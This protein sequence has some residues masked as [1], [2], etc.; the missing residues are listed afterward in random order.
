MVATMKVVSW[1]FFASV[2]GLTT[3]TITTTLAFSPAA[4]IIHI[5]GNDR[6]RRRRRS[7]GSSETTTFLSVKR[8][9]RSA[10]TSPT[11][12]GTRPGPPRQ[13]RGGAAPPQEQQSPERRRAPHQFDHRL[14]TP[15]P[16][17]VD[18]FAYVQTQLP[19][20]E[21]AVLDLL[22]DDADLIKSDEAAVV[23]D[24]SYF[25]CNNHVQSYSLD[26][27]FPNL[28]F[29]ATF[30]ASTLFRTELRSAIRADVFDIYYRHITSA[31]AKTMLL[32][33]DSSLQG[34]WENLSM[35]RTTTVLQNYLG[36]LAPTGRVLM[37]TI[38]GLCRCGEEGGVGTNAT[39]TTH[40]MDIVGI[41]NRKIPHSWHQDR[42][43]GNVQHQTVLWGF[44]KDDHYRGT[45]VFS[46]VIKLRHPVRADATEGTPLL[47]QPIVYGSLTTTNT[48]S[49]S[50]LSEEELEGYI[51]R[52]VYETGAEIIVYRDAT[53]LHSA[54]DVTY[55]TSLMRF[56]MMSS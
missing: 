45:G 16:F 53:V 3:T 29:S 10:D 2:C 51:Y 21:S 15:R 11:T 27:L 50:S 54:P 14:D 22:G 19:N 40:W 44:P 17:L 47:Q 13:Q 5:I 26:E 12:P 42:N 24:R 30:A 43:D 6:S 49:S 38:G 39:T 48:T 32:L 34:G 20:A 37:E 31:K 36:P 23:D 55:R 35:E 1:F 56:M 28:N 7:Y 25:S 9:P 46:H 41:A 8:V 18:P 52:P 4:G 33:P